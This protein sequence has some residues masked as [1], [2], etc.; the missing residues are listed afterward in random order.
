MSRRQKRRLVAAFVVLVLALAAVGA[1]IMRGDGGT[2]AAPTLGEEV[3]PALAA[4]LAQS[5]KFAPPGGMSNFQEGGRTA[6]DDEWMKHAIPG[7]DIP[8]AAIAQ[9]SADWDKLQASADWGGGNAKWTPL[10]PSWGKGLPNPYRD[11]A[12]YN[13]GTPDFSG[14]IAHTVIDPGCGRGNDEMGCRLWIANAN[15]GVWRTNNALAQNPQWQYLSE[16]FEHN[17][18]NSLELDPNDGNS[19][20]IWA[21]TGESNA[22][23]SGCE[24][25][26]GI[27]KSTNSGTKWSGPFGQSSGL[28]CGTGSSTATCNAFYNRAVASI[29]VKPGDSE[30]DVRRLR[31]RDSRAHE[32]VLRRRRR[33]HPGSGAL[34]ALPLA[35]RRPEL[36]ARA[37]GRA[38]SLH[39]VHS[40][41]G[42]AE[43]TPCSPRGARRVYIDPVDPNTVYVSFFGRGIWRSQS[44]GDPGTWEQIMLPVGTASPRRPAAP[45]GPSSTSSSCGG[46]TRMYV[47]VGGGTVPFARFRRNDAVRNAPAATVRRAGSI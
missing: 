1:A 9:S 29:E 12:V 7:T 24:A 32:L 22:C 23:G 39:R 30:R 43:R 42:L 26:V 25:G 18:I 11:R 34:R 31:P 2:T 47:G 16:E 5:A 20:T 33:A 37:P 45:S 36:G 17:S 13:A 4:K 46:E 35:R 8:S 28:A 38:E 6:E 40:G 41:S 19:N 21:G 3:A 44:N 10:G 14:R 27:Y 15:G